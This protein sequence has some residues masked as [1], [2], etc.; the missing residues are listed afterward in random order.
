MVRN[1]VAYGSTI[2]VTLYSST[3]T[4]LGSQANGLDY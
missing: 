4:Y 2:S 1:D 3:R